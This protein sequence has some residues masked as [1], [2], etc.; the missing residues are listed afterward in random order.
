[1]RRPG[2]AGWGIQPMWLLAL[3]A[4]AA[5]CVGLARV[6]ATYSLTDF[7]CFW[8]GGRF[9]IDGAD[10]Y[11]TTRWTAA[12]AGLFPDGNGGF[13]TATCPSR[14]AYPLWTAMAFAPL[15]LLPEGVAA[16]LWAALLLVGAIG[17]LVLVWRAAGGPPGS[18]PTYVLV[19]ASS[20]PFWF[21]IITLQLGGVLLG[22][23]GVLTAASRLGRP[24]P[25]GLA[26][27]ALAVK[28]HVTWAVLPA[29][30][31]RA[32]RRREWR[33]LTGA[34]G[35]AAFGTALSLAIAPSWPASWLGDVLTTRVATV[36]VQATAWAVA[37][38]LM[39]DARFAIVLIA[40][41]AVAVV[42]L[43]RGV[44]LSTVSITA[45][46]IGGSLLVTPY[47]GSYDQLL[48][49]LPWAVT[50]AIAL[51]RGDAVGGALLA[52]VVLCA[53]LL[54]WTLGAFAVRMALGEAASWSVVA[55]TMVVLAI[56][57]RSEVSAARAGLPT[58]RE[59]PSPS[60]AS[61]R[62]ARTPTG[63]G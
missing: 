23:L 7:H 47:A 40:P 43:L 24:V 51:R 41:L 6:D 4:V 42:L 56:A 18:L 31:V 30:A 2:L 5:A 49:A 11:D 34:T 60:P 50:L 32:V 53:S 48:L 35:L 21:T 17:G 57:L 46:G 52:G 59:G 37:G 61:R 38:L 33:L 25:A 13:R 14:F 39:G 62:P 1:L 19:V 44:H 10:P 8:N 20:Q 63:S 15:G 22:L 12:T 36:P 27:A 28:P 16:A 29:V 54:P 3:A 45:L 9:V 26:L 55:V 58:Y